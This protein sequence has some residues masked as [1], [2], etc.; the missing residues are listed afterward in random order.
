MAD[1]GL[2]RAHPVPTENDDPASDPLA[3]DFAGERW[4]ASVEGGLFW[5]RRRVLLVAD[6]HLEKASFF[7]AHGQPLPPYDSRETMARLLRLCARWDP[8][9]IW[10]LGDSFH[11]PDGQSRLDTETEM[12][13][14]AL[15]ASRRW[16]FIA[17]NHD[18][19]PDG[20]WGTIS[21]DEHVCDGLIFRHI[22]DPADPRPQLSGHYHP[23][24]RVAGA[25]RT[26][27][28]PCYVRGA[29]GLILPAFGSLTGGMDIDHPAIS[30][31]FAEPFA[32]LV[33][34]SRGLARFAG[35]AVAKMS[36]E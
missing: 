13:L 29:H 9:E 27:R 12:Q 16:R 31:L 22:H 6:L 23:K 28:R 35:P 4:I 10:C 15:A 24:I 18:G 33:A 1:T 3:I 2:P 26:L 19:L 20:R 30:G 32:A 11:D 17:G 7:A 14:T 21:C 8:A 34:T 36:Q 5:P 25:R